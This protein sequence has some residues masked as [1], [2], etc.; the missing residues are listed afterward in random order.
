MISFFS[1]TPYIYIYIYTTSQKYLA[2]PNF[3]LFLVL[4][5]LYLMKQVKHYNYFI[6]YTKYYSP[7]DTLNRN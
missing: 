7:W 4:K 5:M 6:Y 1:E 3:F 2:T